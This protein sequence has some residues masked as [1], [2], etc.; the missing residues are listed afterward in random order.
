ME[1]GSDMYMKLFMGKSGLTP[2]VVHPIFFL[3]TESYLPIATI[4]G[5]R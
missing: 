5:G 4:D 3:Q 1:I 2:Q